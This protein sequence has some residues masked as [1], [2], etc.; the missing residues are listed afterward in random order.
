MHTNFKPGR[1]KHYKGQLY[2]ALA[3][4]KHS[5]S[6]ASH[7]VYAPLYDESGLWVRPAEMFMET[8]NIEGKD[9][10]RFEY[11]GNASA[12]DIAKVRPFFNGVL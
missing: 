1:Y 9:I 12:D 3:L 11:L 10:P 2:I 7:V 4:S 8:V 6:L 5:E